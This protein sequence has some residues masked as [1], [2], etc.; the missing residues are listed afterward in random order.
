MTTPSNQSSTEGT[1]ISGFSLSP[2]GS[3]LS[4]F[5]EGLPPGIV[6]NPRSGAISGTPAVGDATDSPYT[7]TVITTE[8]QLTSP[9]NH[10]SG[11]SAARSRCRL[12]QTRLVPKTARSRWASAAVMR[13]TPVLASSHAAAVVT[14]ARLPAVAPW[15][16]LP[17]V[18]R[19]GW[20]STPA[21]GQSRARWPWV[22]PPII[23]TG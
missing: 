20:P 7:V 8:F 10:S 16:T 12:S 1:T 5:A 11:Q 17:P 9:K 23:R 22:T 21:P 19:Q 13:P 15:S 6:I 3:G 18:C 4:F 14:V 2:C